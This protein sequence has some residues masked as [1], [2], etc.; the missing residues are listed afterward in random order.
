MPDGSFLDKILQE[1]EKKIIIAWNSVCHIKDTI[2]R[3][4]SELNTLLIELWLITHDASVFDI[5]AYLE[6]VKEMLQYI[7]DS[8]F[9][10]G[11][12]CGII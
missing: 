11:S 10:C 12:D 2:F 9:D 5:L 3:H 1:V 4:M 7:V 8:K 6:N